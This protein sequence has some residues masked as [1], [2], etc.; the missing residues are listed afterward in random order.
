MPTM[1]HPRMGSFTPSGMPAPSPFSRSS[2]FGFG[3]RG[4]RGA[5]LLGARSPVGRAGEG[6][7][8]PAT[9]RALLRRGACGAARASVRPQARGRRRRVR[10]VPAPH[11]QPARKARSSPARG[12]KNRAPAP[13]RA[14]P[15]A[16]PGRRRRRRRPSSPA[17]AASRRSAR[18]RGGDAATRR[19][20]AVWARRPSR[21]G[22]RHAAGPRVRVGTGTAVAQR[23]AHNGGPSGSGQC[24]NP[25]PERHPAASKHPAP[26]EWPRSSPRTRGATARS[27]GRD[28]EICWVR[29]ASCIF[30][31][32]LEKR[33]LDEWRTEV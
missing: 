33:R 12:P 32:V 5:P 14:T 11:E 20:R 30:A 8:R 7:V 6:G 26:P 21:A 24:Q 22:S 3:G 31:V 18:L 4:G 1:I 25:P 27:A 23:C 9:R 16:W 29:A 19:G 2:T 15:P 28:A 17:A 10:G 13:S